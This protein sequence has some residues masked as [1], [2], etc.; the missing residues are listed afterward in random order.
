MTTT[1]KFLGTGTSIGVPV[2]GCPCEVCQSDDARDKRLR[3]SACIIHGDKKILIDAGLDFR[4]QMLREGINWLDAILLTH[5]HTDHVG[6]LD[7]VRPMNWLHKREIKIYA[8]KR[9]IENLKSTYHYAFNN[10]G[11]AGRPRFEIHE[12]TPSVPFSIGGLQICP[13]RAWHDTLPVVGFRWNRTAYMTDIKTLEEE[14]KKR[15]M[16][17]DTLVL[18]TVRR[19]PTF[20]HLTLSEALALIEEL[21]PQKA[22]LTHMGHEIGKHQELAQS[23]PPNVLPAYDGLE[24]H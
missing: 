18:N 16:G 23:L 1:L 17:L 6:G 13:V 14:D 19:E 2:I 24:I 4:Q 11:Y 7:D 22:F 20:S 9:V 12:L 21:K 3:S 5:G 10:P 8:E 15:L